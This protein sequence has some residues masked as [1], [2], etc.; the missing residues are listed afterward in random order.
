MKFENKHHVRAEDLTE[1]LYHKFCQKVKG[2]GFDAGEYPVSDWMHYNYIGIYNER[3]Y[4]GTNVV[5]DDTEK[6]LTI[7]QALSTQEEQPMSKAKIIEIVQE[8]K[9]KPFKLEITIESDEDLINLWQR[10]DLS[11]QYIG[12]NYQSV[13]A[14]RVGSKTDWKQS[15]IDTDVWEVL[16]VKLKEFGLEK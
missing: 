1:E 4:H 11:S 15:R 10:M 7:E 8:L 3:I 14:K 16:E 12:D 2:Q 9:F 6:L 13:I 5:F